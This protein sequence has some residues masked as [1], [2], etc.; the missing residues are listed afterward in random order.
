MTPVDKILYYPVWVANHGR[1]S[2]RWG[3][4]CDTPAEACRIG[5]A[6]VDAGTATLSFVVKFAN[7][8]K[9]PMMGCTKP[10]SARKI[11]QHWEALWDAVDPTP[12]G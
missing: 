5:K 8:E 11:I 2:L 4:P 3:K 6:E 10:E 1:V 9:T 7:G 12:K